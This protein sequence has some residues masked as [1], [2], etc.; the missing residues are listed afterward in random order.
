M[1][2]IKTPAD[3]E[4]V[5]TVCVAAAYKSRSMCLDEKVSDKYQAMGDCEGAALF[6]HDA[7]VTAGRDVITNNFPEAERKPLLT[8]VENWAGAAG[9][10][11]L[12]FCRDIQEK[13]AAKAKAKEGSTDL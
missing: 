7:I 6:S 10:R 2:A 12:L 9:T 1:P 13:E 8:K 3:K 5:K 11:M 4:F